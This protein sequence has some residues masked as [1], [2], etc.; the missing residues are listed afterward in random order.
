MVSKSEKLGGG[1]REP[2]KPEKLPSEDLAAVIFDILKSEDP[3]ESLQLALIDDKISGEFYE[4]GA[5]VLS[6]IADA[7]DFSQR[8]EILNEL[9]ESGLIS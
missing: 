8:V 3:L 9:K 1:E 7:A 4:E 6:G 2:S 5:L